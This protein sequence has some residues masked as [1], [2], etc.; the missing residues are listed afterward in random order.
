MTPQQFK[1]S[2]E[3]G[4]GDALIAF[5]QHALSDVLISP[6]ALLFLVEIGLPESAAPY[7]NFEPP[8]TGTLHRV[9]ALWLQ[10]AAFDRYRV[11]GFNGSG[12]P[13]CL[14]EEAGGQVVYLNHDNGFQRVLMASSV[15]KL[16]ECLVQ[17]R[18]F[19][20]GID[21][22]LAPIAAERF[23][24]LLQRLCYVD[25]AAGGENGFWHQECKCFQS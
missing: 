6:E 3:S 20:T 19:L 12:D 5:P 1:Q 16:A 10:K 23:G 7:L 25:P 15:I 14:D 4:E 18:D 11:I 22:P 24:P 9:S 2:W 21:D 13:V 17:F 8:K